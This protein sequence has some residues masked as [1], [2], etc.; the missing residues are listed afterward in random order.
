MGKINNHH[1]SKE[2]VAKIGY[3]K[4]FIKLVK[5]LKGA[6]ISRRKVLGLSSSRWDVFDNGKWRNIQH[7]PYY[8]LYPKDFLL[9]E[10]WDV[11]YQWHSIH[12]YPNQS[13]IE[14]ILRGLSKLCS[15]VVYRIRPVKRED[16]NYISEVYP[17][18]KY[19]TL[20][21]DDYFVRFY[22]FFISFFLKIVKPKVILLNCGSYGNLRGVICKTARELG[23]YT[24]DTQHGQVYHQMPYL[25]S[26]VVRDSDEYMEY[27][28]DYL[29]CYGNYWAR[30]VDWNYKKIVVGNPYLN[31]FV[32]KY[33]YS[34]TSIDYL[35]ISQ[36]GRKEIQRK[37]IESLAIL[38]PNQVIN[39]R[40][41]PVENFLEEQ[42]TLRS[43]Q[44]IV[45]TDSSRNLYEHMCSA[46]MVIGW[47]ST[48]LYELLAFGKKPI[49]VKDDISDG[50]FPKDI[51]IWIESVEDIKQ[52]SVEQ[53]YETNSY[54][55]WCPDFKINAKKHLDML[56]DK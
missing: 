38:Y 8:D 45:V 31:E 37:F 17:F 14:T 30:C 48:C 36:P 43:L 24:I 33:A 50:H 44:N 56:L 52:I 6:K 54:D 13:T 10:D 3:A 34:N 19:R 41:H 12:S 27:M 35:V 18:I 7:G 55:F 46:R 53:L 32:K 42:K 29:Y 11:R 21:Y 49:I 2:G 51:G 22:S 28:P 47:C 16:F 40:L 23:I 20:C 1:Y 5:G 26:D 25:A 4:A 15:S 9:V 39:V